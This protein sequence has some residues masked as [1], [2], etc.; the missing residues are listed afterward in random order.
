M[1][2]GLD[3]F[4]TFSLLRQRGVEKYADSNISMSASLCILRWEFEVFSPCSGKKSHRE[5]LRWKSEI[6]IYFAEIFVEIFLAILRTLKHN[7]KFNFVPIRILY[8]V[9]NKVFNCLTIYKKIISTNDVDT[10]PRFLSFF[11]LIKIK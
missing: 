4:V 6:K 9:C 10:V 7:L 1:W 3:F 11:L 2:G 5:S 8:F